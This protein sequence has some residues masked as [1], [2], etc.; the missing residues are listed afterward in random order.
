MKKQIKWGILGTGRM[1]EIFTS[2]LMHLPEA[3]VVAVGSRHHKKAEAF[4]E[5][6]HIPERFN[7]YSDLVNQSSAD[8]IYV[9]T[10]HPFHKDNTILALSAG[11]HVLCEKPFAINARE[12]E[13]M[14]TVS[15]TKG[16]F[17][18]DALWIRFTPLM[19]W[20]KQAL[21]DEVVGKPGLFSGAFGYAMDFNPESRVFNPHLGGGALL[22][23]G[24]Y[25]LSTSVWL[26]GMPVET[27]SLAT[28]GESGIDE[29]TGIVMKT[30]DG[31]LSVFYTAVV[32]RTPYDFTVMGEKGMITVHEPWWHQNTLTIHPVSGR[33]IVKHFP[34][35]NRGY[36][37]M[38]LHVMS[39]I[40][41]GLT[42]SPAIPHEETLGIMKLMDQIREQIG[43]KYP[44][45]DEN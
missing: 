16:L 8:I 42:E 12:A 20:L 23:V 14:I 1:A 3:I 36:G 26:L 28:L 5:R 31:M 37:Y 13:S 15:Q 25:P 40:R 45:E 21:E 17:L 44:G 29:R 33:P 24:I 2:E 35:E 27:K 10:P 39:C 18:M 7:S 9:A 34:F 41:K 19:Q 22:D 30:A 38:A 4:G 11:K 6:F 43:L 32:N